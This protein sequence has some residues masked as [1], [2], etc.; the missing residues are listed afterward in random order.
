MG[1]DQYLYRRHYVEQ[2]DHIAPEKQF[3]VT[4]TQ[5]GEPYEAIDPKRVTFVTETICYWRKANEIHRWFVDNVQDGNDDC[6]EY[7]VTRE[8]LEELLVIVEAVLEDPSQAAELLPTQPGFFFGST[9][10]DDWYFEN[11]KHTK[12]MLREA[13]DRPKA[14]MSDYFYRA[15]W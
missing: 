11:L 7:Y 9:D 1:L 14:L 3:S 15:S 5:G 10:Y 6:R 8:Q 4:V 2:W 13:L 12:T